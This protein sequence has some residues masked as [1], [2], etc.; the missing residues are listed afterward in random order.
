M[1]T[2]RWVG[3]ADAVKQVA[4]CAIASVDAT[5]ANNTFSITIGGV[6]VTV[7]GTSTAAATAAA[8]LT[9]LQNST[10]PY[11]TAITWA[12]PS[13]ATI[14]GTA[15]TAGVPFVF[16]ISKAG[17]GTG[18]VTAYS[19]TTANAGPNVWAAANFTPQTLP[20]NGDTV[21]FENNSVPVL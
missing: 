10:H 7:T 21:I 6:A 19:V 3:T 2:Y 5:P 17:V 4:S 1:S 8:L 11:F 9:E 14:T 16:A 15:V 20:A 12:N 13:G 18:T